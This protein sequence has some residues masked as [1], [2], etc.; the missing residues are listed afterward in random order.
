MN[1]AFSIVNKYFYIGYMAIYSFLVN[2][3]KHKINIYIMFDETLPQKRI[4][5]LKFFKKFENIESFNFIQIDLQKY[6]NFGSAHKTLYCF[7][8]AELV[9]VDKMLY[10]HNVDL[11]LK[12]LKDLYDTDISNRAFAALE[13]IAPYKT[14]KKEN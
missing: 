3:K 7:E 6:K 5:E 12:D 1:V 9:N 14:I 4:E 11:V 10:I 13:Y 8:L 2:N